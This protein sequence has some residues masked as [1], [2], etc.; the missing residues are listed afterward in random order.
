[1]GICRRYMSHE[2][3]AA[4]LSETI[5]QHEEDLLAIDA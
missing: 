5:D 1:V 4:A 2:V 3:I